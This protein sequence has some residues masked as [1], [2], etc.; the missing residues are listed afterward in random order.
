MDLG[1][2]RASFTQ[3]PVSSSAVSYT[4]L[5]AHETELHLVCRLLLEKNLFLMIRRPPRSTPLYSSAASDV[6]KRQGWESGNNLVEL[7]STAFSEAA[8]SLVEQL[9]TW[10]PGA[11]KSQKT[12]IV[13]ALWFTELACRDRVTA[14]SGFQRSHLKNPFA[15]RADIAN[16]RTVSLWE[17]ENSGQLRS[18]I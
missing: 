6:Y 12:D 3:A 14:L 8:K 5:R 4:H 2:S 1:T 10:Y 17:A 18:L 11:A 15:T 13:M 7:P 16:R 9:V